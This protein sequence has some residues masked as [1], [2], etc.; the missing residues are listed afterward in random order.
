MS[1]KGSCLYYSDPSNLNIMKICDPERLDCYLANPYLTFWNNIY[2]NGYTQPTFTGVNICCDD[3]DL[4]PN[5]DIAFQAT[6]QYFLEYPEQLQSY[7]IFYNKMQYESQNL[8]FV[9][10]YNRLVL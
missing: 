6:Y 8:P 2:I 9:N 1:R 5:N 4:P 3:G 7:I 10:F